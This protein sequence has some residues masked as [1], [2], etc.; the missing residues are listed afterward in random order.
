[1][2]TLLF[3]AYAAALAALLAANATVMVLRLC[4]QGHR[5][6]R[7]AAALSPV[8]WVLRIGD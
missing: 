1:M 8:T 6:D 4:R 2:E 3:A 7:I 5:A